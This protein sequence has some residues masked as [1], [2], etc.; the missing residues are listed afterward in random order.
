MMYFYF[1]FAGSNFYAKGGWK[2]YI[3]RFYSLDDA[4]R[5]IVEID[6]AFIIGGVE[7]EWYQIVKIGE[8]TPSIIESKG[9]ACT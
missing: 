8:G 3:D 9:E 1:L 7:Y 2:D 4:Y 6:S 5:A